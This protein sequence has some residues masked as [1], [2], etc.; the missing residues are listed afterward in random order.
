MSEA[1]RMKLFK[2]KFGWILVAIIIISIAIWQ[3]LD[4]DNSKT[5]NEAYEAVKNEYGD[6]YIPSKAINKEQMASVYGVSMAYVE[7]YIGECAMMST[8]VDVFIGIKAA[9]GHADEIKQQL[10]NYKEQMLL[11][12]VSDP[13]KIAK[14]NASSVRVFKDYVFFMVLGQNSDSVTLDKAD[15]VTQATEDIKRGEEILNKVFK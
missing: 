2:Y 7:D 12:Y 5:L 6:F 1:L 14:I 3:K 8:H 13:A 4:R 15:Y 10:S 11:R 9:R